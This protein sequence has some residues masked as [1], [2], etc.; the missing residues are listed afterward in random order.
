MIRELFQKGWTKTAI[1]ELTGFDPKTIRKYINSDKVP[2]VKSRQ[3]KLSKLDPFKPYILQR[4]QEGT[5]NCV[6]LLEEIQAMG[7]E[8]KSTILRDF[9]KPYRVQPKKQATLRFETPPGKQAQMDWAEV[10]MYEVNGRIQKVY[11]FIMIL[12]YSRM[13]YIEFTTDMKLET[14]MKCHMNAFSYFNGLPHHILYD[15][16]KTVVIKHSPIEIRFNRTFEDFLAYYGIVPKACK[17]NRPQTKGKVE[18]TVHYLKNNFFQRKHEPTLYAL[19][20]DIRRWLDQ[21]ANKKKNETTNEPPVQRFQ[22][23]QSFLQPWGIKPLFPTSHWEMREVSRDCFVSYQGKKYSVPF[24]YAGQ[25]VKIKI[26]LDREIE[27]YDEQECMAKHPILT[28]KAQM[29]AKKEHYEGLQNKEKGQEKKNH[30]G[31]AT[32]DSPPAPEVE[33]RPLA[34]YAALEEGDPV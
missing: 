9:V 1:A 33:I 34:A 24:R 19:N 18:R 15:N 30:N 16:M 29:I 7:Y 14:L 17:P 28:E 26:T 23:E 27:I 25:K 2:E 4:I 31:L 13:K 20:E 8:G 11:A 6:V 5:T 32:H 10:G 12:G 21:T 3:P 22:K